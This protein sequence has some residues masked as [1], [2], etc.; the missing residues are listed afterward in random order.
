MTARFQYC[1]LRKSSC[2]KAGNPLTDFKYTSLSTNM[3]YCIFSL[4]F[5]T[6][7]LNSTSNS[8]ANFPSRST[9]FTVQ[10]EPNIRRYI[11]TSQKLSDSEC[12]MLREF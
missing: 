4:C 11:G 3:Q 6:L 8:T 5:L 9:Q 1:N 2:L 10:W 7:S 12:N